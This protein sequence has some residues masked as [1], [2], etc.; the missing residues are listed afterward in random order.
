MLLKECRSLDAETTLRIYRGIAAIVAARTAAGQPDPRSLAAFHEAPFAPRERDFLRLVLRYFWSG[1]L[2]AL[3]REAFGR[4][5]VLL[6]EMSKFRSQRPEVN[7]TY[8]PWHLDA[9]FYGFDVPLLTAWVPFM[10]VGRTAP[11]LE[12]CL[13]AS[14]VPDAVVR[15]FWEGLERDA[16][17]GRSLDPERIGELTG[18][19][20]RRVAPVIAPGTCFVFD[21]HVL[22]RTQRLEG[23]QVRRLALEFRIVAADAVPER[24]FAEATAGHLA[25]RL[26]RASGT[27]SI[28]LLAD[29]LGRPGLTA[30]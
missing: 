20:P 21:Q 10:E 17:G 15:R 28:A 27:V 14:P 3:Y 1:P 18:P 2:P 25:A 11:G 12:F 19:T 16:S 23:A 26:D 30:P 8:V 9:N 6:L 5:P 13:P 22:H 29:L 24:A 7:R 4:E